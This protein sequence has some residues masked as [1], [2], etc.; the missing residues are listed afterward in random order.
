[1]IRKA[2]YLRD[3]E[4]SS[5]ELVCRTTLERRK[6]RIRRLLSLLLKARLPRRS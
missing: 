4:R 1:M 6:Q 3:Q 2:I 5:V